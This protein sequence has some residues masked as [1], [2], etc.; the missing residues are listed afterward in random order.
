VLVALAQLSRGLEQR[1]NKRP[2]LADLRDSGSLEQDADIVVFLFREEYYLRQAE[3]RRDTEK[4]HQWRRELDAVTD[5]MEIYSAKKREGALTKRTSKF[6]TRFQ[7]VL[8]SN[9]PRVTG[10]SGL[11]DDTTGWGPV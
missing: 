9:D 6:L 8:D 2:M 11:F 10:H 5:D 7:A 1:E 4:W 3:P